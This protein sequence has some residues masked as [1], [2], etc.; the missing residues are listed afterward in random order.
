MT[1]T[2]LALTLAGTITLAQDTGQDH[3]RPDHHGALHARGTKTMGFDQSLASH[4]FKLL[5]DGGSIDIQVN[6][7]GDD[8][9][10]QKVAAHLEVIRAQFTAGNFGTPEA[11]H[12]EMPEGASEMARLRDA[13]AYAV[14]PSAR[15]GA[16]RI[17]AR[18]GEAVEAVHAFLRYQIREHRT[19]DPMTIGR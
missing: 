9:T 15:G 12:A 17:T 16:L 14:E 10:R 11:T 19:G 2:A 8:A 6:K 1:V 5:A 7:T 3:T 13:I 18:T 4:H